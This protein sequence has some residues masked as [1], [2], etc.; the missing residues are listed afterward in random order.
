MFFKPEI[1]IVS[2]SSAKN[3]VVDNGNVQEDE[4]EYDDEDFEV[5]ESLGATEDVGEINDVD[6]ILLDELDDSAMQPLKKRSKK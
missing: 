6:K 3:G 4:D 2:T 1:R 5:E